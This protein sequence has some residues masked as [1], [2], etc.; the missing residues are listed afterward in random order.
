MRHYANAALQRQLDELIAERDDLV[1]RTGPGHGFGAEHIRLTMRIF[2]I[3]EQLQRDQVMGRNYAADAQDYD[4]LRRI[5][6]AI[7]A[8]IMVAEQRRGI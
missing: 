3:R 1:A 6:W 5:A 4:D 8:P 2:L 7:G